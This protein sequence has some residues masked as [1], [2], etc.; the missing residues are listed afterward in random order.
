MEKGTAKSSRSSYH[1][2]G[3][4]RALIGATLWLIA[5]EGD[6]GFTLREVARCAKA[7]AAPLR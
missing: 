1:H 6:N 2:G 5:A 4:R 3:L 7:H